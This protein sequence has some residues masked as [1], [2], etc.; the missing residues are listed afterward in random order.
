MQLPF[1][2]ISR[3]P[4]RACALLLR[5]PRIA[6]LGERLHHRVGEIDRQRFA[7]GHVGDGA[8]RAGAGRR[9]RIGRPLG[10]DHLVIGELRAGGGEFACASCALSAA[11]PRRSGCSRAIWVR[12]LPSRP[13]HGRTLTGHHCA[14][15]VVEAGPQRRRRR[16]QRR[17]LVCKPVDRQIVDVLERR[18]D[19]LRRGLGLLRD[20]EADQARPSPAPRPRGR[21]DR[22]QLG[23]LRQVAARNR[24]VAGSRMRQASFSSMAPMRLPS[25]R[26]AGK[27]SLPC[28]AM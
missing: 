2:N 16:R 21:R 10:A 14:V 24:P 22:R 17:G 7:A 23:R 20:V 12:S 11:S 4:V 5:V 19:P 25:N 28:L 1:W 18:P 27:V 6:D 15:G 26:P 8:V 3:S 9:R 13:G